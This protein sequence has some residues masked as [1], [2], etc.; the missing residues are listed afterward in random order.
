MRG[1]CT[2][3]AL[4]PSGLIPPGVVY[5]RKMQ[6][7]LRRLRGWR[8]VCSFPLEQPDAPCPSLTITAASLLKVPTLL[9]S[10][11]YGSGSMPRGAAVG[12]PEATAVDG[13]HTTDFDCTIEEMSWLLKV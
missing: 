9:W 3:R 11:W 12:F 8:A 4:V 2:L 13:K 5:S 6:L 1:A 7:S 10:S